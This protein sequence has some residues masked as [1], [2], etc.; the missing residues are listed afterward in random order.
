MVEVNEIKLIGES[1][2]AAHTLSELLMAL[3]TTDTK[4]TTKTTK[5]ADVYTSKKQAYLS[6]FD[7]RIADTDIQK[8]TGE[9]LANNFIHVYDGRVTNLIDELSNP[10]YYLNDDSPQENLTK[11][12]FK[13]D[14][15]RDRLTKTSLGGREGYFVSQNALKKFIS[16][17]WTIAAGI[18]LA[19]GI[20]YTFG[21]DLITNAVTYQ[22]EIEL[23]LFTRGETQDIAYHGAFKYLPGP[24]SWDGAIVQTNI[25][26]ADIVYSLLAAR[27]FLGG[28]NFAGKVVNF[29]R[30][31]TGRDRAYSKTGISTPAFNINTRLKEGTDYTS[32]DNNVFDTQEFRSFVAEYKKREGQKTYS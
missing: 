19:A 31:G 32:H 23:G 25:I 21:T 27:V 2:Q 29:F 30:K 5:K 11:C 18:T 24:R 15:E 26:V 8:T 20:S 17:P 6:F 13:L 22:G 3:T 4:S 12:F 1:A 7:K 16:S 28:V 9:A 10:N 14:I